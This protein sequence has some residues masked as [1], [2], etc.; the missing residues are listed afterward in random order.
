MKTAAERAH[1]FTLLELVVVLAL[2]A[3]TTAGVSLALRDS[4]A[5][6]LEREGLRLSAMLESARAQS[7][8]SGL[9][10]V[11]RSLPQ[12]FE[13]VG[14]PTLR[15]GRQVASSLA[16][17]R[18]WLHPETRATVLQP[19]GAQVL[20]LGPEPL[21]AAQRIELVQGAHRLTLSTDGLAPF[22]VVNTVAP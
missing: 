6:S 8:T 10:V 1:G 11:W 3:L 4:D 5:A 17:P 15:D 19:P 13:F 7:R 20:V 18:G 16:G 12:G 9:P 22:A 21:I 2:V 14:L